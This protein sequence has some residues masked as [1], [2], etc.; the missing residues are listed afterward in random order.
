MK[1]PEIGIINTCPRPKKRENEDK[2]N[3]KTD[4]S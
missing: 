4:T 3:L 1:E 2:K